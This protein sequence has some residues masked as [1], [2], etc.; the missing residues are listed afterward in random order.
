MRTRRRL[1]I[2]TLRNVTQAAPPNVTF[3]RPP[4]T[5]RPCHAPPPQTNNSLIAAL[6]LVVPGQRRGRCRRHFIND[7]VQA[8]GTYVCMYELGWCQ[9][10]IYF[11]QENWGGKVF[12][13]LPYV[14]LYVEKYRNYNI[15]TETRSM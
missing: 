3:I 2:F 6:F 1:D 11:W 15:V 12:R 9:K 14:L 13:V 5:A 10:Y 8:S 7:L 4:A